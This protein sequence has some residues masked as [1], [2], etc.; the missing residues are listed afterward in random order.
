LPRYKLRLPAEQVPA[1]G[2]SNVPLESASTIGWMLMM[3]PIELEISVATGIIVDNSI[4]EA[5][6]G[7][8]AALLLPAG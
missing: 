7:R 3:P 2:S 5:A 8:A 1:L 6:V 4:P